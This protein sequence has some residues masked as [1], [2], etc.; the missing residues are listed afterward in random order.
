MEKW[1][2]L[3]AYLTDESRPVVEHAYDLATQAHLG[4]KRDGYE[5]EPF[6]QHPL[7]VALILA[8]EVGRT[9]T[10]L[11][12]VALLHDVVED[13]PVPESTIR[14]AF[15]D[16]VADAVMALTK[17]WKM[18]EAKDGKKRQATEEQEDAYY[19]GI[20]A[21]EYARFVKC[22]DRTDNLRSLV[23][24]NDE[25]R[26]AKY[27]KETRERILPIADAT[28]PY[29]AKELRDLIES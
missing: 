20:M 21:N 1:Q 22:A 5:E 12:A 23:D 26:W 9:D 25:R 18:A 17:S 7:R 28:H 27:V 16:T 13:T 29:F 3:Q 24:L 11:L 10:T 14:D 15:G 4:Q 8:D 2:Q 19:A 6:I